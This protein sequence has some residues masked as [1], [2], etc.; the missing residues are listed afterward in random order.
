MDDSDAVRVMATDPLLPAAPTAA[1]V[2]ASL[3]ATGVGGIDVDVDVDVVCT[4]AETGGPHTTSMNWLA[5]GF[6]QLRSN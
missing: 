3:V 5:S 4:S 6:T 2:L 1:L